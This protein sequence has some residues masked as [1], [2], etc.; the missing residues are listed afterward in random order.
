AA[1]SIDAFRKERS[2]FNF[3]MGDYQEH[4]KKLAEI[5]AK[6]MEAIQ[7]SRDTIR[8]TLGEELAKQ[9]PESVLA[10]DKKTKDAQIAEPK[11]AVGEEG[12]AVVYSAAAV[13]APAMEAIAV[14][15]SPEGGDEMPGGPDMFIPAAISRNDLNDYAA[16]LQLT[17]QQ[18]NVIE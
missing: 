3:Q 4:Q 5:S 6:M 7:A 13:P 18:K 1:E 15:A 9:L 10:T 2:P 8:A 16:R 11:A 12:D 17:D 14:A